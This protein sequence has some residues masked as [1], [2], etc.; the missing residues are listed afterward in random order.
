MSGMAEASAPLL[1]SS[2]ESLISRRI[3]STL[4]G[5][6]RRCVQAL[7]EPGRID[8]MNDLKKRGGL[9][10]LIRLEVADEM[11]TGLRKIR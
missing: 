7:Q 10:G 2:P 4:P 5:F 9:T 3:S 11:E 6:S 8:G 1:L